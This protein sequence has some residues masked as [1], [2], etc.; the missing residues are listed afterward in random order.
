MRAGHAIKAIK[1]IDEFFAGEINRMDA[2]IQ[3]QQ[4]KA[5]ERLV[6]AIQSGLDPNL[7]TMKG[8]ESA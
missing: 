2:C 5:P 1:V 4:L 8:N 6:A 7:V 3:L